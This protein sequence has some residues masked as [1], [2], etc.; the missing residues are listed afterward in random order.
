M[1]IRDFEPK[2]TEE[3]A[4]IAL[5]AY[6]D[7]RAYTQELPEISG[8]PILKQLSG[9]GFGAAAFEGDR[10]VGFLCGVEP[11]E[12]A[13]RST[14]VRGVFSPMGANGAV[15]DN[16]G[17]IYAAL[18]QAAAKKWVKAGAVS[19]AICL[20]DHDEE[21]KQQLFRYGFGMRC[22]DAIR[23]MEPIDCA[24]CDGY[25][26]LELPRADYKYVYPL[27]LALNE[28]YCSSPFFMNRKP[29]TLEAFLTFSDR[30]KERYFAA[31]KG[32]ELCAYLEVSDEGE[33]FAASGSGYRHI[34]GAYCLPE[35]RGRGVYQKLLDF[36]VST[37]KAEGYTRLGVDFES[38]N[39]SGSG[40]WL[41]HFHAYTNSVVR[42]IDERILQ[43]ASLI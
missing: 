43:R 8:I 33:T 24:A 21:A 26:F 4:E 25:A 20:Y 2:H 40:F 31:K 18:Y 13:F 22:A 3:A 17:R 15:R 37:L 14:D 6:N 1:I 35:H 28:H 32:G 11:F 5:G 10:M 38:V 16:H 34:M 30:K 36:A 42:R 29:D 41:K 39:P 27:H 7:E 9:N 19:H 12:H 23:P